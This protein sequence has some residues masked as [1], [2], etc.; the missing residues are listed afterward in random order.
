MPKSM[1]NKTSIGIVESPVMVV[2]SGLLIASKIVSF[3]SGQV[4]V[5]NES[6]AD[7]FSVFEQN[8]NTVVMSQEVSQS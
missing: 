2:V 8:V 1:P 3:D 5:W 6:V 7:F 4:E